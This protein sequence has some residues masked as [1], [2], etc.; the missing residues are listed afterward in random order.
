MR[1]NNNNRNQETTK[2]GIDSY[3]LTSLLID[4]NLKEIGHKDWSEI[5]FR[6]KLTE[7]EYRSV[8]KEK[9]KKIK[10]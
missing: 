7:Q 5:C 8:M 10:I 3:D 1:Q 4:R 6:I 2:R 9:S